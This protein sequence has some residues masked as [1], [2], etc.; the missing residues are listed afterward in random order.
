MKGSK[1]VLKSLWTNCYSG[2][3]KKKKKKKNK[4]NN[5]KK[6]KTL[7]RNAVKIMGMGRNKLEKENLFSLFL[8]L[9]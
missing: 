8:D 6:P 3:I 2:F 7:I 9:Y 5:K 1:N 4:N